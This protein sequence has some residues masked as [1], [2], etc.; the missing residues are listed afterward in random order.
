MARWEVQQSVKKVEKFADLDFFDIFR[1]VRAMLSLASKAPR[2]I[3]LWSK[4]GHSDAS[5]AL[6]PCCCSAQL[7]AA[8]HSRLRTCGFGRISPTGKVMARLRLLRLPR[9]PRLPRFH[10]SCVVRGVSPFVEV[11]EGFLIVAASM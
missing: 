7:T 6:L 3:C 8:C 10:Q 9:L 1:S 4:L 11:H 2:A 5:D